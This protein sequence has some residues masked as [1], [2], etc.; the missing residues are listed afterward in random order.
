MTAKPGP[1]PKTRITGTKLF[2]DGQVYTELIEPPR[3]SKVV[4]RMQ[5]YGEVI[6]E[7]PL[8]KTKVESRKGNKF[9]GYAV[10]ATKLQTV[11]MSYVK[12]R[13][14]HPFARH[15]MCVYKVAGVSGACEDGE[16]FGD[17][18]ISSVFDANKYEDVAIFVV[19]EP[20]DQQ[21]GNT[22]L[23]SYYAC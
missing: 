4:N 23:R 1:T 18:T 19:R 13:A 8:L 9:Y 21:I 7:I 2:V 22:A 10:R 3:P 6:Q 15:I 16:W 14:Q 17:Q 12:I 5:I 20:G 11:D